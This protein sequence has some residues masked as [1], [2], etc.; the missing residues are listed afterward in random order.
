L[1]AELRDRTIRHL[2]LVLAIVVGLVMMTTE[3]Q[4]HARQRARASTPADRDTASSVV[5]WNPTRGADDH[6]NS[7]LAQLRKAF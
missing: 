1:A 4:T 3:C 6:E 5:P 2:R 7:A